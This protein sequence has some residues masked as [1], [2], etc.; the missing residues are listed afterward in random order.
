[1]KRR[2]VQEDICE[3]TTK[4]IRVDKGG[5]ALKKIMTAAKSRVHDQSTTLILC[6]SC[7]KRA[8]PAESEN[9]PSNPTV[10]VGECRFCSRRNLC[11]DC[12]TTCMHCGLEVCPVCSIK[13]YSGRNT[14]AVCLDC[15]RYVRPH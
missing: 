4:V 2:V 5:L 12:W 14:S 3:A 10:L 9:T 8:P 15:K 6:E 1:M 13:D 7:H 11:V